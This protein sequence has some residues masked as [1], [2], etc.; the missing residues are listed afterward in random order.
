MTADAPGGREAL[1]PLGR[2]FLLAFAVVVLATVAL[3]TAAGLVGTDRGLA[4]QSDSQREGVADRVAEAAADAYVEAGGW[5][6]ADLSRADT[7]AEGGGAVLLVRDAAGSQVWPARGQGHHGAMSGMP[8]GADRVSVEVTADG[9]VVGTALLGFGR[10]TD[11]SGRPLAWTW[12]LL[13]GVIALLLA[14]LAAWFVTRQLSRPVSALTDAARAFAAGERD[15][16]VRERGVGEL[17]VLAEA[18]DDAVDAVRRAEA[19]RARM[20]ADVAHEL[21]T[22][23]AALQAGLEE[24]RDGLAPAD[25]ATLAGL[26]DQSLRVARIVGDLDTLFAAEGAVRAVRRDAV[27]LAALARDEVH[28]RAAQL[29]GADLAVDL[30]LPDSPVTVCG[31]SERL[32]QV[33]GNLLENCVRHC[34]P[35]DRVTV[36]VTGGESPALLVADTGPGIAKADLPRIFDRFWRGSR[37][38][39]RPGSGLG[40][41]V[42]RSLVEAMHGHVDV[43]SDGVTGTR[44]VIT[45]P[46]AVP[47][48]G[49]AGATASSQESPDRR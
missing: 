4:S 32:H 23:L 18:F 15:T 24:L 38:A 5:G 41:A 11:G 47:P 48:S 26:H 9:S 7:V 21:R 36:R 3:M 43:D 25:P 30:A 34:R 33:L 40:L 16:V 2:R 42:V 10:A 19:S 6:E 17:A 39:G 44:F 8:M 27:D 46:G 20:A 22:P 49:R 35:G 37:Q 12:I 14:L 45:L 28:A 1:G 13:A 31:D 29:R